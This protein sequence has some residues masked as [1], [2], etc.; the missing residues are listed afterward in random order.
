MLD[1][2]KPYDFV[3]FVPLDHIDAAPANTKHRAKSIESAALRIVD[4]VR[5][6]QQACYSF[7]H[8]AVVTGVGNRDRVRGL[9]PDDAS[10]EMLGVLGRIRSEIGIVDLLLAQ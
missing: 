1:F 6:E 8:V 7:A 4:L 10:G 3:G 2:G 5:R 9:R